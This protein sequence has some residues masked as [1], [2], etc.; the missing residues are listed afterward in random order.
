MQN[1]NLLSLVVP[2]YK[3]EKTILKNIKILDEVLSN[4]YCKYEIIVVVDG[5][6]DNTYK[7]A[8]R[9]NNEHIKVL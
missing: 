8:K 4:T 9:I 6:M 7:I 3:Q 1:I 2:V 5:F